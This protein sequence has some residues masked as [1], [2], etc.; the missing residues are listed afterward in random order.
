M[1]R[2]YSQA[3]LDRAQ[4]Y[5][6]LPADGRR[7]ADGLAEISSLYSEITGEAVGTCRQCQYLDFLAVVTNYI[8]SAT[9]FLHPE[10][11]A[12]SKY[13]FAPQYAN[14]TIA[15]G[16]YD[17]SV[18]AENITDE[19]AKSLLKLGYK[20]VIVLKPTGADAE[21]A[22]SEGSDTDE[23]QAEPTARETALQQSLDSETAK[24]T[25]E[26]AAHKKEV[27]AHKGTKALLKTEKQAVT[28]L[29]A[30]LENVRQELAAKTSANPV[31]P[32]ADAPSDAVV[33]PAN[34]N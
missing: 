31:A 7:Y 27:D 30:D 28:R 22:G 24:Y 16:R 25:A 10:L 23:D 6:S 1:D 21:K 4:A 14:E 12:D 29:T 32:V 13:T 15:D 11:M 19:D 17:K 20:H 33:D 2:P 26:V 34:G 8:R 5:V 18:T 9:R 3:L